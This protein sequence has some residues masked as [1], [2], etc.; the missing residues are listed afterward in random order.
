MGIDLAHEKLSAHRKEIEWVHR[1]WTRIY[2][3]MAQTVPEET[4]DEDGMTV[5]TVGTMIEESGN[6]IED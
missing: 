3:V 2:L 6:V 1:T 4:I 5:T